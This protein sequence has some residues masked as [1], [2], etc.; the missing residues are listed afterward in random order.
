MDELIGGLLDDLPSADGAAARA[1]EDRSRQVLRPAGAFA[2]L[3]RVASWL[4]GWQGTDKPSVRSPAAVVFMAD[5]GVAS[6]GV[7]A[8]PAEVTGAMLRALQGGVATASV[9]ARAVG[10]E[11]V[12]IMGA[13]LEARLRSV[14]VVL[15]GFVATAAVAPLDVARPGALD[16]AIAGHRSSEPGH[17]LLLAKLGKEPLLELDLRLGEGSGGL[18]AVPLIRLAAAAVTDVATFS[19]WGLEEARP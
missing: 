16:H 7:S 3:D 9:L 13:T 17:E 1:V 14:P 19:E 10:A 11:L 5:H 6:E 4:A 15:D 12:A 2:R 18:L 8:Y